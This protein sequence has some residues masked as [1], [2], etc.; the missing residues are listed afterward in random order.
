MHTGPPPPSPQ[1]LDYVEN[2]QLSVIMVSY[3]GYV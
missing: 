3:V 1:P 2:E